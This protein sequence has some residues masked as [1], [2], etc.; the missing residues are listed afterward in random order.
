MY[1]MAWNLNHM[2]QVAEDIQMVDRAASHHFPQIQHC[3]D[4]SQAYSREEN[5]YLIEHPDNHHSVLS[6]SDNKAI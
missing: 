5:H 6:L 2:R 4:Y 3:K 1:N